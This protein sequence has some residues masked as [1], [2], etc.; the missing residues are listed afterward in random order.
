MR[1]TEL[2]K[3]CKYCKK[4]ISDKS[5]F[6][7]ICGADAREEYKSEIEKSLLCPKCNNM[8][9]VEK[10]RSE[11][12]SK[13]HE[14]H[15]LW[16]FQ[17]NFE[18]LTSEHDVQDDPSLPSIY[19][20]G[21]WKDKLKYIKCPVCKTIMARKNFAET[22]GIIID[23]CLKH[24]VFL[25][26]GE[27]T[28]IREFIAGGGMAKSAKKKLAQHTEKIAMLERAKSHQALMNRLL[29]FWNKKRWLFDD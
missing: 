7:P 15:G 25:D 12:I 23:E 28:K 9:K 5:T 3:E 18:R 2:F 24:G 4:R 19:K 16:L 11:T 13:C 21:A 22:S 14:C 29:H 20:K 27:L 8:F 1:K 26:S 6:C 17:D 10:Y